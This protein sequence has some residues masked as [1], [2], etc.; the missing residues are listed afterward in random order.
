M[1]YPHTDE[2]ITAENPITS[3]VVRARPTPTYGTF[4]SFSVLARTQIAA[5]PSA[6]LSVIRDTK[7]W[8]KWN[9]FCPSL[10]ISPKSPPAKE[11]SDAGIPKG[12]EGW[13]ELGTIAELDVFMSG[14]G[15]IPG[16]KRS[17]TQGIII[18]VLEAILP[19]AENDNKS[20]YRIAWK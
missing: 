7:N 15:L 20:G 1:P 4:G 17:R 16:A 5:S 10:V 13:L 2:P 18:T 6:V 8:A 9:S 11:S 19:T 12:E 14:D 3:A